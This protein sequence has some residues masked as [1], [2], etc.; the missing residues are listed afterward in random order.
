MGLKIVSNKNDRRATGI[1]R[2]L[3]YKYFYADIKIKRERDLIKGASELM[4]QI[5][6]KHYNSL[7][8]L[9]KQELLTQFDKMKL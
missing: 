4:N 7:T 8:E 1:L 3:V 9:Q 6:E 2:P 5:F